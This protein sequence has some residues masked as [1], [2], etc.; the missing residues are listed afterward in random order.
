MVPKGKPNKHREEGGENEHRQQTQQ[1]ANTCRTD[2]TEKETK[3]A[4]VGTPCR[5][6]RE[7]LIRSFFRKI[8]KKKTGKKLEEFC[9]DNL[10]RC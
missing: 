9:A 10:P 4:T 6:E 5:L 8:A 7:L 3:T 2:K 1:R